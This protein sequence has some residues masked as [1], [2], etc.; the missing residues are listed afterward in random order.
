MIN[1]KVDFRNTRQIQCTVLFENIK[2]ETV[3]SYERTLLTDSLNFTKGTIVNNMYAMRF[4]HPDLNLVLG[5]RYTQW[6]YIVSN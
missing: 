1:F 3:I 5:S 2:D 6:L 4:R